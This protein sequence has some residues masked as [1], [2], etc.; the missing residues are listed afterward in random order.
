MRTRRVRKVAPRRA[1]AYLPNTSTIGYGKHKA[2]PGDFV[3]VKV[4]EDR[5]MWGRV[6]GVVTEIDGEGEDLSGQLEV[7]VVGTGA[8]HCYSI[9]VPVESVSLCEPIERSRHFLSRFFSASA[10]SL[11]DFYTEEDRPR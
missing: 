9:V 8:S 4:S 10:E 11:R 6:V 1:S 5:E 3:Q 7:L 2:H